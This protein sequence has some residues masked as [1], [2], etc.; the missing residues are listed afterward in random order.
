MIS[1][2]LK[3]S[4]LLQQSDKVRCPEKYPT[5]LGFYA[6]AIS[7]SYSLVRGIGQT[8][9]Q[10]SLDYISIADNLSNGLSWIFSNPDSFAKPLGLPI[11]L[12]L[13]KF[14][15]GGA[16]ILC[17]KILMAIFHGLTIFLA[18]RIMQKLQIK[19]LLIIVVAFLMASDPLILSS[20]TDVTTETI[21]TLTITYW[22]YWSILLFTNQKPSMIEELFFVVLSILCILTR[23]NYFFVFI[24]VLV[25]TKLILK[26]G[27]ILTRPIAIMFFLLLI[28][29]L[30][31]CFLYGGFL[32]LAP[33][34]GL[35]IY[36][37]CKGQLNPQSL[38]I[39]SSSKNSELNSWVLDSLD[40]ASMAF[41]S[42]STSASFID[43]NQFLTKEGIAYCI[44]NPG[45]GFLTTLAKV[46]G[47][48]RPYVAFGAYGYVTFIASLVILTLITFCSIRFLISRKTKIEKFLASILVW[49]GLFFTI[50][51]IVTPTQIR[52][53]IAFAETILWICTG[54]VINKWLDKRLSQ[55]VKRQ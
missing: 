44:N 31:V 47:T 34:S 11:L 46:F 32:F 54:V 30:F 12:A 29:E 20:T 49:T 4:Y 27:K 37:L 16:Y 24:G 22:L 48:W 10:D 55:T 28:Y 1:L 25:G 42:Q 38:G 35:G 33:G 36:F 18:C 13:L 3:L 17:F 5:I 8:Y 2:K 21:A 39:L 40:S 23:P 52:H 6:F 9:S 51:I 19:S 41:R 50:T 15:A 14:I 26:S 7:I 45:E 53:R 43:F